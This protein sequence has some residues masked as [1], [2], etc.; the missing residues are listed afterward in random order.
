MAKGLPDGNRITDSPI[1]IQ[2]SVDFHISGHK[3]QRGGRPDHV[4]VFLH[5]LDFQVLRLPGDNVCYYTI[6]LSRI[7]MRRFIVIGR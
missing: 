4:Y 7:I 5:I 3:R 1:Q 6:Y 2:I